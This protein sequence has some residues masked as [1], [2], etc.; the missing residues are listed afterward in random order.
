[1]SFQDIALKFTQNV[2]HII[3]YTRANFHV[4]IMTHDAVRYVRNW[5]HHLP[6]G[7]ITTSG[8]TRGVMRHDRTVKSLPVVCHHMKYSV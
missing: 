5:R 7:K 6:D 1:M 3:I 2:I 4:P 8:V